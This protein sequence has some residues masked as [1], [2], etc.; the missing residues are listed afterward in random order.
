MEVLTCWTACAFYGLSP[1]LLPFNLPHAKLY[2]LLKATGADGLI[3]QAG[4]V[5]L[6][7]LAQEVKSLKS[8]LW[9]VERT[10][11]HMDW[12]GVPE[13]A[14]GRLAVGV[15]HDVVEENVKSA[16]AELPGNDS[17]NVPGE[18]I[19][20]WQSTNLNAKPEVVAFTQENIVAA[21]GALIS[22]IP[23]RQRL[24]SA[25]LVLP[26]DGFTHSYVLCQTLAAL[27]MHASLAIN[28]VAVPGV[29][30]ELARRGVAPTV[31]IASAETLANLHQKETAGISSGL[32][33]FGKYTQDQTVSAGRMPTDGILFRLLAPSS[34]NI[35]PGKLRLILTSERLGAGSPALSSTMLSDLRIYTRSRIIYALTTAKVAGAVAQTNVFDYRRD[36]GIGHAHFGIPL[37]S[38]E[39]KLLNSGS[40]EAV[41]AQEPK[42]EIWVGGPAVSGGEV[43]LTL[44]GR[45]R[46]DCTIALA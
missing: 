12:N 6:E 36:D 9:V 45:I 44:Q 32:Q 38:V 46:E 25:D 34:A 2:E 4:T 18:I 8:L 19:T 5:P 1:V 22:A 13:G 24:S 16:S 30:L 33:K 21:T 23:L 42:G 17:G 40:D 35:Q 43:R 11:R 20:V 26:A 27:F 31:I 7:D 39:V 10:S 15:W 29:D 28:S 3:C 14:E 37:S 41:A